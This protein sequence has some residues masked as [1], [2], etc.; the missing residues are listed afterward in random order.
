MKMGLWY[1]YGDKLFDQVIPVSC[2]KKCQLL[3][4]IM[5]TVKK[6]LMDKRYRPDNKYATPIQNSLMSILSLPIVFNS[7][8]LQFHKARTTCHVPRRGGGSRHCRLWSRWFPPRRCTCT[9]PSP[10]RRPPP[11]TSFI[12]VFGHNIL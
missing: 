6:G 3:T 4:S 8:P 10:R 5:C 7:L 12:R 11:A 1:Y 9:R 2:A